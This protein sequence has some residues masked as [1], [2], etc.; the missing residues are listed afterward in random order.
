MITQKQVKELFQYKDGH[1][2]WVKQSSR[3]IKIGDAAGY[4]NGQGYFVTM[5]K[6]KNYPNHRLVFLFHNG[7]LPE[8][9]DHI[10]NNRTN[11]NIENLRP[12]TRSENGYNAKSRSD[13]TTGVKGVS[14][15]KKTKRWRSYIVVNKK[16]VSCGNFDSIEKAEKAVRAARERLHLEFHNHG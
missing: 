14:R 6:G 9:I 13:N 15:C 16:Q 2:I 10:D 11:N 3:R 1:L 7:Y 8:F 12:C 4:L 5:I